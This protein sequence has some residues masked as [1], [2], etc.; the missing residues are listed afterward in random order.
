VTTVYILKYLLLGVYTKC[1]QAN[2][3]LTGIGEL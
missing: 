1:C 3:V 2:V